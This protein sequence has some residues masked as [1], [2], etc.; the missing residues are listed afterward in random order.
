[1]R[2]W[3]PELALDKP[4]SV[5]RKIFAAAVVVAGF[6][7]L[8]KLA[9]M[10]KELFVARWFGRGD[11][12]D[13]F[14]IALV[15]PA[16]ILNLVAGSFNVSLIPTYVHVRDSEGP[17]SAN[18]LFANII[19]WALILLIGFSVLLGLLAPYFLH[20][21]ASGFDPPKLAL[22]RQLLYLLLPFVVLS[23]LAVIFG[24]V[25][26]AGERFAL[27]A[28]TPAITPLL[29]VALLVILGSIWGIKALVWGAVLG[30]AAQAGLLAW[31]LRARGISLRPRWDGLN[32]HVLQVGRQVLPMAA[33]AFLMGSTALVDQTMA[34]MLESGSVA[35]LN[36]GNKLI[37]AALGIGSMALGTAVLPYFSGMVSRQ[38]WPA[39]RHTLKTYAALI[40]AATV[41]VTAGVMI[42]SH[43][44]I[45]IFFQR[46]AFT[47]NDTSLVSSIQFYLAP[48]IPFY[49]L[50]I[51]GV[52]LISAM[53]RN[54]ALMAIAAVN[55]AINIVLN[56]VLMMRMGVAGIA[57]STSF[58]Y[59]CS[60]AMVY[61]CIF[62]F[63]KN[64]RARAA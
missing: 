46:G 62:Y 42:L 13:A 3:P 48:Q 12:L 8:A 45:R 57:L 6:S 36:Y 35:A 23:G 32:E 28:F 21:L 33:G 27:P 60:A 40:L 2:I 20:N 24:A 38:D 53:K 50:G 19:T 58:V 64:T 22:T 9:G 31:A 54:G 51:L 15:V 61:A 41:P 26:N 5:N 44:I 4:R 52:R 16:F 47:A 55:F 18:R 14:L 37:S 11:A 63:M 34:A 1:M 30:A 10:V 49:A 7:A 56:Y 17:E 25:L 29:I 39:C 59:F 43:P